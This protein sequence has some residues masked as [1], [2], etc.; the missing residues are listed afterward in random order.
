M[1]IRTLGPVLALSLPG[2]LAAEE[3]IAIF[4]PY[5]D[6]TNGAFF[7]A[8]VGGVILAVGFQVVLTL[9]SLSTGLSSMNFE[10]S[11]D[12]DD[13][14]ASE[15]SKGWGHSARVITG[16]L[17]MWTL[18]SAS[19]ALFFACW[20]ALVLLPGIQLLEAAVLGLTIWGL[21]YLL[22][23]GIEAMAVSSLVGTLART[24]MGGLRRTLSAAGSLFSRSPEK[25]MADIAGR[26]TREVKDELLRDVDLDKV[27]DRF[28]AAVHELSDTGPAAEALGREL[29]ELFNET[30]LHVLRAGQFDEDAFVAT[31]HNEHGMDRE[32]ARAT[33]RK[34]KGAINLLRREVDEKGMAAGTA[35]AGMQLA[36]MD[37][38]QAQE[39]RER[40]EQVLRESGHE[41]LDPDQIEER[42]Q[43]VTDDPKAA[44]QQVRELLGAFD[45]DTIIN[46][47]A[48]GSDRDRSQIDRIATRIETAIDKVRGMVRDHTASGE[49]HGTELAEMSE[50]QRAAVAAHANSK[51][52]RICNAAGD[53]ELR[54]EALRRDL[55]RLLSEPGPALTSLRDRLQR[56]D[57]EKLERMTAASS[58]SLTKEQVSGYVDRALELRDDLIQRAT[59]LEHQAEV[60]LHQL[61]DEA[62]HQ[63]EEVRKTS[64][65]AAWWTFGAAT[66]SGAAAALGAMLGAWL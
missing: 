60:K 21:F 50:E 34:A 19:V 16:G 36:G 57:R 39:R 43:T 26:V 46:L 17:G 40:I 48:A 11:H 14:H 52:A 22:V 44:P 37:P 13:K 29:R 5:G 10:H 65:T 47:I 30:E 27:E 20:L 31:L 49:Q 63:A 64:A 25:E 38:E 8:L 18:V 56:I 55:S 1:N 6:V 15:P 66:C 32:K 28:F 2:L 53:P 9:L 35:D 61:R 23:I 3:G 41:E 59:D 42:I 33:A 62:Q 58:S 12:T 54:Y 51:L 24:A 45:R 4:P 7:A